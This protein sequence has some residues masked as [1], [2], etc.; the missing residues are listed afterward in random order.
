MAASQDLFWWKKDAKLQVRL[1]AE[2]EALAKQPANAVCAD[3]NCQERRGTRFVSVTL[4]TFLCNRCYGLHRAL[5]AH[6]TRGKCIGLD[7]WHPDEV[8]LLRSVGNAVARSRFENGAPPQRQPN[9]AAASDR[10]VAAWIKDKYERRLW[11]AA[12][13]PAATA[14]PTAA[15]TPTAA[16]AAPQ[17][18]DLLSGFDA[19]GPSSSASSLAFDPRPSAAPPPSVDRRPVDLLGG[20]DELGAM[21]PGAAATAAAPAPAAD[22]WAVEWDAFGPSPTAPTAAPAMLQPQQV[23]QQPEQAS[24]QPPPPPPQQRQ[25]PPPPPPGGLGWQPPPGGTTEWPKPW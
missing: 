3:C 25:P 10:D 6:V 12:S 23:W 2:V 1:Q 9:G 11:Y 18:L 17:P 22:P 8:Q 15:A 4:G 20:L 19:A 21:G 7:A 24:W 14:A 16:A 13:P 5:G